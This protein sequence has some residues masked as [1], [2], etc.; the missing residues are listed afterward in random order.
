MHLWSLSI[1]ESPHAFPLK[2][3]TQHL[4]ATASDEVMMRSW[5]EILLSVASSCARRR[6]ARAA[7]LT[8][9]LIVDVA[10]SVLVA[11]SVALVPATVPESGETPSMVPVVD[12]M[13]GGVAALCVAWT[14]A[15]VGM[16]F[17]HVGSLTLHMAYLTAH[18]IAL[19]G[20]AMPMYWRLRLRR[21]L[22]KLL[23]LSHCRKGMPIDCCPLSAQ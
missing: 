2:Q 18:S 20:H 16:R 21:W 8:S 11:L 15:L 3:D 13:R 5:Y 23:M 14:I 12:T 19:P 6:R 22:M 9:V 1:H 10:L 7:K 17:A 4:V